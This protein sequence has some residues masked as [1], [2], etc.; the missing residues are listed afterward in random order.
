MEIREP[1][2][3]HHDVTLEQEY[4][5]SV[6]IVALATELADHREKVTKENLAEFTEHWQ[7]PLEILHLDELQ[8]GMIL[9][10]SVAVVDVEI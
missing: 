6:A 10:L 2:R 4:P 1:I 3:F 5:E 8:L 9:D 7:A